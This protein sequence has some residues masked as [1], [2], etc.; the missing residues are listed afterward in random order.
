MKAGAMRSLGG[1]APSMSPF[2][3]RLFA[4]YSRGYLRRRF[5]SIRILKTGLP[6]SLESRPLVIYLN[7]ASWWDPLVCLRLAQSQFG[8]RTSY[9]P[10]DARALARYRFFSKLGFY[11]VEQQS[12][13]GTRSFLHTTSA[14][15]ESPW[16]AVWLTPQGRFM[17]VRERPLRLQRGLGALAAQAENAT[18]LP[19]AIEY[20]FWTEPRAEILVSFGGPTVPETEPGRSA[21]E[22]TQHFSEALEATQDELA[23]RSCRRNPE[24][25]LVLDRSASSVNAAYDLCRWAGARMKGE[26]F[27]R[28]HQPEQPG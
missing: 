22:W 19:L 21:S 23:A 15:L 27:T 1:V 11:G 17:D 3:V 5:H 13:R 7:H 18:F 14:I 28:E 9:A 20:A 10:I 2:L 26:S 16:N 6:P 24:E 8:Q 4:T 25:W 12:A